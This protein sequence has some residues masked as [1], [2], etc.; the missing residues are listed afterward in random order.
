ML[1]CRLSGSTRLAL[2]SL[3]V[4]LV[5]PACGAAGR[6]RSGPLP[7]AQLTAAQARI[8]FG[9]FLP[10][11]RS[12]Q[13]SHDPQAE[14]DLV[15]GAE[16]PAVE[17]LPGQALGPKVPA[18]TSVKYYLPR[19]DGY[20]RWFIATGSAPAYGERFLFLLVQAAPQAGWREATELYELPGYPPV[21]PDLS[22]IA[23]DSHGYASVAPASDA[24]LVTAPNALSAGF[25]RYYDAAVGQAASRGPAAYSD[26]IIAMER[27]AVRS[28]PRYGWRFT[29][30]LRPA[31]FPVY[32][33]RLAD[34]GAMV[35]FATRE[36]FGWQAISARA[37]LKA[38]RAAVGIGAAPDPYT[39]RLLRITSVRAGLRV[40]F[41]VIDEHL[42][43]DPAGQ[44]IVAD[45]F[46]GKITAITKS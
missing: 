5:L 35:I 18:L 37:T 1:L 22:G 19:L 6:P 27:T 31:S 25:A 7:S 16:V 34:G 2:A 24:S 14:L 3:A 40:M 30:E 13:H 39:I 11:F 21:M 41:D 46:N 45:F 10:A 15:T 8:A 12:A 26:A 43:T 29:D 33:L 36:A 32:A 28:A 23:V 44:G 9:R 4:L 17:Q 20:P 42:A 38:P